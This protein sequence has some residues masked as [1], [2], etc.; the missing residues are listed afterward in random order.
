MCSRDR[1]RSRDG[2]V[3]HY[4]ALRGLCGGGGSKTSGDNGSNAADYSDAGSPV[5]D[6]VLYEEQTE[7]QHLLVFRSDIFGVCLSL[8]GVL[9][10]TEVDEH[11][12]HEFLVHVPLIL[13][14]DP[15]R[16][17]ICGGGPGGAAR[18]V[19]KH[20]SVRSVCIVELDNA[21]VAAAHRFTPRQSA[22][23]GDPRV[24]LRIA[25]AA[26]F[27]RNAHFSSCDVLAGG[28]CASDGDCGFFDAIVVDGT[29]EGLTSGC[30]GNLTTLD[31]YRAC[32]A[33]LRAG[34]VFST[35]LGACVPADGALAWSGSCLSGAKRLRAA[36]FAEV[37]VYSAEVPSYGGLALF[38]IAS[39]SSS[40]NKSAVDAAA[41]REP[42]LDTVTQRV[43][44]R[45]LKA[46]AYSAE[47]HV[48]AFNLPAPLASALA[49]SD[50]GSSSDDDA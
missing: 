22:A 21:V 18:E 14:S 3:P 6:S 1:S 7:L 37:G 2:C 36:G 17:L 28:S 30:S 10:S 34:G 38:A 47:S 42:H 45:G 15:Q 25:D 13:C 24:S 50:G 43:A 33:R 49:R 9:Q 16:V 29:D 12:Y 32:C 8:D 5:V 41:I 19:L 26:E 46:D 44:S 20:P 35:Q 48:R 4:G 39:A 40:E 23:L 31:F 11:V 27:V